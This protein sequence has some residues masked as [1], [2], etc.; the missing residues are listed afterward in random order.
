MNILNL[1]HVSKSYGDRV[2]LA[3]ADMSLDSQDKLGVIGINGSGKST[4]LRLIAGQ[5]QPD[6]GQVVRGSRL[7]VSFLP[8]TPV[9]AAGATV[10]SAILEGHE[11]EEQWTLEASAKSMLTKLGVTDFGEPLDRL[12]GGQRK[13]VALVRCLLSRADLLILDEPT[14]H[15]DAFMSEWLEQYLKGYRGALVMVT[16]D[17]YF[18]DAVT[19]RIV[20]LDRNRLYSY[21]ANYEGYLRQRAEREEAEQAAQRK[22]RSLLRVELEWMMRG[23]EA[24]RTKQKF[25]IRQYEEHAAIKAPLREEELQLSSLAGRMGKTTVEL[26]DAGLAFDGRFLFRNF[27]YRFLKNDRIGFV[28]PNGCGKTTLMRILAGEL[29]LTE[30]ELV[31]GQTIRIGY[32][33]QELLREHPG[34][35]RV[36]DPEQLVIDYI[37]DAAEYVRT[38]EGLVSASAMLERFL[39][40]GEKQ[41]ARLG[42]L[43]GGE[44]RRLNL[45][46][47]LM[48]Q[49]N[50]LILDEPTND[51][52]IRTLMILEDYLDSF[53]GIVITVS[54][55]RYFL[56]RV[57]RRIFAFEEG[58]LSPYEGGYTDYLNKRPEPPKE[59]AGRPEAAKKPQEPRN[60][61]KPRKLRFSYAEQREYDSI[62]GE[63]ETL[64]E[65]LSR[66]DREMSANAADYARL[67]SL[68]AEK[69]AQEALLEAK[70]ERWMELQELAEKIANQ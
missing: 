68:M 40:P 51:L 15:L 55:D 63:I 32:Y 28:G 50:V 20:E 37:R 8:Q 58:R 44:L 11:S 49:P 35:A 56:D 54:H 46:R 27:T 31:V 19:S 25:K 13:R 53:P 26:L 66:L 36:M 59:E 2:I 4:L 33:R 67:Q 24:R 10:L 47:V 38:E 12:S 48:E 9:F 69:T 29:A 21:E 34:E 43:S 7:T 64:E 14:N 42:K 70:M 60:Q 45:L 57:V 30:G 62:E 65:E 17:R 61:A 6:E 39:F 1:E 16:H 41:Y 22:L 52:D 23:A 5:E 18:L 3:G